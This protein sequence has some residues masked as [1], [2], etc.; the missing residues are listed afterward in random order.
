[1]VKLLELL[2]VQVQG[3]SVLLRIFLYQRLFVP[4]AGPLNGSLIY[5]LLLLFIWL[6]LLYPLYR[7]Q[8]FLKI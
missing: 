7:K 1:M 6:A 3:E 4:W 5:P 2:R 8:I